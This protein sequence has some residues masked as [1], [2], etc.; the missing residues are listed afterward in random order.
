VQKF[1]KQTE[2]EWQSVERIPLPRPLSL[3]LFISMAIF[4]VSRHQNVSILD[5]I[6]V[7]G[8]GGGG[9]NWNYKTCKAQ[10]NRH[11][12][13]TNTQLFAG[14]MPFL[15]PNQQ[16]QSTEWKTSEKAADVVKKY[17]A[18]HNML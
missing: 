12:R 3:S 14:R 7:K 6:E 17:Q 2:N 18:T 1:Q 8:D 9:D 10:S 13:Q 4:Q 5:F 15:S 11:H 16:H